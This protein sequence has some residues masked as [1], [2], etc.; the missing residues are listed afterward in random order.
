MLRNCIMW[1]LLT[2]LVMCDS[3]AMRTA[4]CPVNSRRRCSRSWRRGKIFWEKKMETHVEVGGT[5]AKNTRFIY[6]T[7]SL[8]QDEVPFLKWRWEEYLLAS[9]FIIALSVCPF[10]LPAKSGCAAMSCKCQQ[11][12]RANLLQI[13]AH[14]VFCSLVPVVWLQIFNQICV[15][16]PLVVVLFFFSCNHRLLAFH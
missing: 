9:V 5:N 6:K 8:S 14:S 3:W 7:V 12:S 2:L 16:D 10:V 4:F 1:L 13:N 11:H 15:D